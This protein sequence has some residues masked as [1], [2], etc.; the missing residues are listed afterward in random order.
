MQP[1]S[2]RI[3]SRQN[4]LL[5]HVRAVCAGRNRKSIFI[6]GIRLCEEAALSSLTI[7]TVIFADSLA[8]HEHGERTLDAL[9]AQT[10]T[11]VSVPDDIFDTLSDTQIHQGLLALARTPD[12]GKHLF[13]PLAEAAPLYLILHRVGNP[14]NA[15]ALLRAA[16]AAGVAG[17][18]ATAGTTY[19][20][21]PKAL[22]G[23]MGAAFRLPLWLG[24]SLPE[25]VA[26]CNTHD[27]R[28]VCADVRAQARHTE[29]D[30]RQPSALVLGAEAQGLTDDE[31]GLMDELIRIPMQP[32]VESLNV[33]VAAGIALYEA[34]RQRDFTF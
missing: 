32:P 9:A 25:A 4:D 34:A 13:A 30:W 15:G 27:I 16:E 14:S 6:E 10:K 12:Q 2:Q 21:S 7:E 18:I 29:I 1:A 31:R 5:K 11:V 19:L 3:T 33:A 24:P 22:R 26:W 23:A 8:R 17:V 28:A 20:Y